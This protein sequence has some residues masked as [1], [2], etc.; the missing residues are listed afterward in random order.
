[1]VSITKI[2]K[3]HLNFYGLTQSTNNRYFSPC[4]LSIEGQVVKDSRHWERPWAKVIQRLDLDGSAEAE[5]NG[6]AE[7]EAD[8]TCR[9]P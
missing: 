8:G 1:M 5:A 4:F 3:I 6:S 2:L 7:A 9:G